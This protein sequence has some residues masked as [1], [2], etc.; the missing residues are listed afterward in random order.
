MSAVDRDLN[1]PRIAVIGAGLAGLTCASALQG[2]AK[3]DVFEAEPHVGGRVSRR[4]FGDYPHYIGDQYLTVTNPLFLN[5]INAW[6]KSGLIRPY[7][8]WVVELDQGQINNLNDQTSR[9][10]G[11]PSMNSI[12]ERLAE[13][14]NLHTSCTITEIEKQAQAGGKWR[15]FDSRGGYQG[16]FD[17]VVIATAA[18]QVA[19]L[20]KDVHWIRQLSK[21]IDMT[22]CWGAVLEFEQSLGLPFDTAFVLNSPLSLITRYKNQQADEVDNEHECWAVYCSPEWSLENAAIFRGRAVHLILQAFYKALDI[23]G[24]K[25]VAS[26]VHCWKHALPINPINKDCVF[27]D[28]SAL[29]ACGDWCTA[30]RIEGAVLSGFSMADRVMK[31]INRT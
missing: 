21:Q 23:P 13:S 10:T 29:G 22:V 2:M 30:P 17:V 27:D 5:L 4:H 6:K 26:N 1:S 18:N 20:T 14:C 25:P 9:F 31:Y 3:V 7:E 12:C 24:V 16:L 11:S 15:I 28:E 19:S 8:G